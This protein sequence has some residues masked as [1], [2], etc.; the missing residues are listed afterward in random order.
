[1]KNNELEL[2]NNKLK[3]KEGVIKDCLLQIKE[4]NSNTDIEKLNNII[5]TK[6]Q[7]CEDQSNQIIQLKE[8]LNILQENNKTLE[9]K[10]DDYRKKFE[11]MSNDNALKDERIGEDENKLAQYEVELNE[12]QQKLKRE[13][14]LLN[15]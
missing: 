9:E 13:L 12:N 7:I 1:M 8:D 2:L 5:N 10:L 11:E 4:L 15:Q 6:S 14:N 3:D